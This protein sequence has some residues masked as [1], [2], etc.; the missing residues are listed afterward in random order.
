MKKFLTLIILGLFI[1]I[2][3]AQ[4]NTPK[5]LGEYNDWSAY[6]YGSGKNIVCYMASTPT[7][8]EGK[9]SKRGD[10]YVVITHRPAEKTFDVVNF[11]AGYDYHKDADVT[12]KIGKTTISNMFVDGDK[13]WA[14]NEATDKTLVDAMK[15]GSKMYVS[16]KSS[17]GTQTKDTYS[18]SGF[19][20]AYQT[21]SAKCRK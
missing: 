11:V 19:S 8:D 10:I 15:K 17:R 6:Y 13:A 4:A 18:L 2:T 21:I 5:L 16:G 1:S 9:Y 20:A 12:I 3:P 14:I 7:K